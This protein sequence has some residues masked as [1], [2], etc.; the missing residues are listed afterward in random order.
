MRFAPIFSCCLL[1]ALPS[2]ATFTIVGPASP[3]SSKEIVSLKDFT[4]EEVRAT[5]ITLAKDL[6]V[7]VSAVGGGEHSFWRELTDDHTDDQ[8]YAYGWIIDAQTR[9]PV[10]VMTFGNTSGKSIHRTSDE[11]LALRAGSYEVYFTAYAYAVHTPFSNINTNIDR[12]KKQEKKWD[13]FGNFIRKIFDGDDQNE[14]FMDHAKSDWGITLTV[15]ETDAASVTQFEPP[16]K[17]PGEIFS[18]TRIG[19]NAFVHKSL[20]VSRDAVIHV[21]AV[22]EGRKKD[23]MF[24]YGWIVSSGSR[25]RIWQMS[26]HS[27]RPAGGDEKN[28]VFSGDVTLPRG[29]Y[30]LYY[31]SDDSH[32]NDDW[33]AAPPSDPFRYG[34]TLTATDESAGSSV[35]AGDPPELGKNALVQLVKA[36]DNDYKSGGFSL[37]KDSKIWVYALGEMDESSHKMADYGWIVDAKTRRRVWTMEGRST[38]HAGGD[39][40]NRLADEV[41][42]LPK[43]DYMVYY[44]TDGSHSYDNWNA[45]PPF[46]EEHWGITVMGAGDDFDMNSTSSFSEREESG[47]LVQLTR[48]GDDQHVRKEFTI[49]RPTTVRVYAVGEGKDDEMDDYGW[50]TDLGSG[51]RIWEMTFD[52]T[53]HAGGA[54]KN[55]MV[56]ET[57]KLKPGK[58]E[59]H[60]RTDD[61]HA[62]NDWNDDPPEDRTHW[63]I[64]IYKD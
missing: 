41:V 1:A 63:G 28:R 8:M 20:S 55:R 48:V 44:E 19:D 25:E 9:E 36:G 27:T 33:N 49:D 53:R 39:S 10:W 51:E 16:M 61:S 11:D 21:Y 30:E 32:S 23:D 15:P 17:M 34:V 62:Y 12:R 3:G 47:V 26:Y 24:D 13:K 4:K 31:I 29:E 7:H 42:E 6:S 54:D 40:K 43:G 58:Y 45:S 46:D 59:V 18:S 50:I 2:Q 5:G 64:T 52:K 56:D 37:K 35:K 22:G 57:L 14:E 38:Y 60:F